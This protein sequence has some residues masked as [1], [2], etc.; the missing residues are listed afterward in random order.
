M[1]IDG[2]GLSALDEYRADTDPWDIDSDAD[3]FN[4]ADEPGSGPPPTFSGIYDAPND[5]ELEVFRP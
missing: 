3:L 2:D 5:C 1:D 4:D